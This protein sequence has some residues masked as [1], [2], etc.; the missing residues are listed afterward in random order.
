[1][2]RI[3]AVADVVD[4]IVSPQVYKPALSIERAMREIKENGGL[5]YD[6]EVVAAALVVI[7]KGSCSQNS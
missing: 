7:K 2:A 6:Q 3:I 5:L 4:T 1:V